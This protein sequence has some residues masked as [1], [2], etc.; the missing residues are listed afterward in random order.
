MNEIKEDILNIK[1]VK[2]VRY[3][4]KQDAEKNFIKE[5]GEDFRDILEFNPLPASFRI[6]LSQEFADNEK[7]SAIVASLEKIEGADEIVY[8]AGY[9]IKSL[10]Y[11]NSSAVFVYSAAIF[12]LLLSL[13]LIYSTNKL[14]INSKLRQY[15]TMKLVGAP[16]T[17]IKIPVFINGIVSGIIAGTAGAFVI[18]FILGIID[19]VYDI[20]F[21]L[22]ETYLVLAFVVL[23]SIALGFLGSFIATRNINLKS[24][25]FTN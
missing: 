8:D 18:K 3:L 9:I 25:L 19:K 1:G 21:I 10:D 7:I 6:K 24:E 5:T 2:S 13:Y 4:S 12:F 11:L 15:E 20:E 17:A 16:L 23:L 14:I 22:K